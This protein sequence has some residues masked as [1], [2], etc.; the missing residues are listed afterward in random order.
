MFTYLILNG[1]FLLLVITILPIRIKKPSRMWL[2]VL[3]ALLILTAIFDSLLVGFDVV[4]YD[5]TKILGIRIGNAPIEDFFYAILAA[6]AIP[7]L[8]QKLDKKSEK[9]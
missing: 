6:I 8:W 7:F 3:L 5:P 9:K 1:I 4:A 2:A